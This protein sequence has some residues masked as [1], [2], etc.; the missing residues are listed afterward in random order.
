MSIIHLWKY[1]D[2]PK[3]DTQAVCSACCVAGELPLVPCIW[4]KLIDRQR[5]GK[6]LSEK[7]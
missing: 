2:Y 1:T 7:R 3:V 5:G 6:V 4:Q